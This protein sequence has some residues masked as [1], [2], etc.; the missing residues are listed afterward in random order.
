MLFRIGVTLILTSLLFGCDFID[1]K[2]NNIDVS[3]IV[4]KASAGQSGIK[5][6]GYSKI[7]NASANIGEIRFEC[8]KNYS[9]N[10][11]SKSKR[12]EY[13]IAVTA[14][15]NYT[16]ENEYLS[17]YHSTVIFEAMSKSGVV[18]GSASAPVKLIV[19]NTQ[20]KASAKILGLSPDEMNK[21]ATIIA[22]WDYGQ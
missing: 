15:I 14:Q 5:Y 9:V 10:D 13:D 12:R 20:T 4:T 19:N 11:N 22:R 21:V 3:K 2:L 8:V 6:E 1:D 16:I 18:L 17:P 7:T